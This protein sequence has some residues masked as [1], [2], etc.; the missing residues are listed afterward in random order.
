MVEDPGARVGISIPRN[1]IIIFIFPTYTKR[2][3]SIVRLSWLL[4]YHIQK[5]NSVISM[6]FFFSSTS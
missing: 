4:E 2:I 3:T 1:G 5:L 6:E